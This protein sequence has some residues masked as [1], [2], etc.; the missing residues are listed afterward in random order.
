[1]KDYVLIGADIVPT[2]RNADLFIN[3][4]IE[5]LF[6]DE[7][8]NLIKSASYRIFNLEVPLCDCDSPIIKCGPNL[9]AP[10]NTINGYKAIGADL[11]TLGNNH[12]LDHGNMGLESTISTL[13]NAGIDF[14]GAGKNITEASRPYIF[15]FNEKKVGVYACS[16]TEFSIATNTSSGANPFDP[17]DSIDH[18]VMLKKE[19]DYLIVLYHGGKEQYRYPSPQ[20]QKKCRKMIL[21][22]ADL[23]VCQHS[24]CVGC[25]EKYNNGTIVYGQGN[26]LFDRNDNEYWKTGLLILIDSDY[27]IIYQ[28]VIKEQEH[29][30]LM[31]KNDSVQLLN[32][33][34]ERSKKIL[35][36]KFVEQEYN[37]FSLHAIDEYLMFLGGRYKF[38]AR[39]LN[40]LS[41]GKSMKWIIKSHYRTNNYLAALNFIECE[42][43]RELLIRGLKERIKNVD[44]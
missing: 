40:K 28:P 1:M 18:I 44:K 11:L 5:K 4:D 34:Y 27:N 26:F 41:K 37:D 39:V 24:H 25:E 36:E 15:I 42:A 43:H 2:Q 12:I 33:F 13:T 8:I 16:E 3:G 6:G 35:D 14:V 30:R 21:K 19:C 17:L 29:V 20:L 9:R 38:F 31:N 32:D 22:G 10:S 7:L 23:V